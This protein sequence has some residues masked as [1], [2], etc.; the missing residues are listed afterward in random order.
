PIDLLSALGQRG[1]E[2]FAFVYG[3]LHLDAPLKGMLL[4]GASDGA[5]VWIDHKVVSS[6]DWPRPERSDE[7]VIRL[8]LPAGDHPILLKLHH[9][10]GYW[11]SHV[12]VVDTTLA[13]PPG[14][15]LRLPGTG[16]G[17]ARSLAQNMTAIE[18]NRGLQASGFRPV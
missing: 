1:P 11:A 12:R 15:Y 18:V 16:D 17:D 5:K 7:D 2:A 13:A 9:R 14:A 8:D 3:V 4:L 10:E 6:N